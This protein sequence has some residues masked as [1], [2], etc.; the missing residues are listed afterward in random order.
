LNAVFA[1]LPQID[2]HYQ[3]AMKRAQEAAKDR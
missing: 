2:E 3:Q 1:I